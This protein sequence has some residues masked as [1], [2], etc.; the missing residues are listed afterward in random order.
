MKAITYFILFLLYTH[1]SYSF[2]DIRKGSFSESFLDFVV[3]STDV[4]LRVQREYDSQR[5]ERGWFGWGWCSNYEE[6]LK[7][8]GEHVEF[9]SCS[10]IIDFYQ[11]ENVWSSLE[12]ESFKLNFH[13]KKWILNLDDG[14]I[15][16]FDQ[17][18]RLVVIEDRQSRRVKIHHSYSYPSKRYKVTIVSENELNLEFSF[19]QNRLVNF[20]EVVSAAGSRIHT[21]KAQLIPSR[22]K[23]KYQYDDD[24]LI[25]VRSENSP[26]YSYKYSSVRNLV[27]VKRHSDEKVLRVQYYLS[28]DAVE[29]VSYFDGCTEKLSYLDTT[30][31]AK[32]SYQTKYVKSCQGK[33]IT[34]GVFDFNY[35]LNS[36]A[37]MYLSSLKIRNKDGHSTKT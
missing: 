18:G 8:D 2:V 24:N 5:I 4:D 9:N 20:V 15:R 6:H 32:L 22:W 7:L 28:K 34:A 10:K 11:K 29:E 21:H 25:G 1:S 12:S 35:Q 3:L 30:K 19:N 36:N 26:I 37:R 31:D 27:H 23:F 14:F 33:I 13:K 17:Q 16:E